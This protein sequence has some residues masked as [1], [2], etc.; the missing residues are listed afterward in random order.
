METKKKGPSIANDPI[1]S[2]TG[3]FCQSRR[4]D[5]V[6]AGD[7]ARDPLR[8]RVSFS[9][10]ISR[11]ITIIVIIIERSVSTLSESMTSVYSRFIRI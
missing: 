2:V 6:S 9:Q 5:P 3:S 10:L 4:A 7:W 11:L 8:A 1:R